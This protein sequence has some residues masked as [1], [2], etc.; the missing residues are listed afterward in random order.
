MPAVD[1]VISRDLIVIAAEIVEVAEPEFVSK[2]TSSAVVG[3]RA[4]FVPPEEAAQ[5]VVPASS[6]LQLVVEHPP[7]QYLPPLKASALAVSSAPA[8]E[9]SKW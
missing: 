7:T 6:Q 9:K 4:L 3:T 8:N 1:P 5:L 2:N